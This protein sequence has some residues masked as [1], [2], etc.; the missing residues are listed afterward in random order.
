MLQFDRVQSSL[1]PSV[2]HWCIYGRANLAEE[3][4]FNPLDPLN[5]SITSSDEV[6]EV[7]NP[8]HKYYIKFEFIR[9]YKSY[10]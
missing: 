6:L 7:W 4:S 10:K 8:R 2:K 9:G 3:K 1:S 5:S